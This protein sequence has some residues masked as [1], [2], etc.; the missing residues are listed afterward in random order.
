MHC[1][2]AKIAL[3]LVK[4]LKTASHSASGAIRAAADSQNIVERARFIW[5]GRHYSRYDDGWRG[6]GW[7]W[8][9]YAFRRG[10]G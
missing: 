4:F 6:P 2:S 5:L 3:I 8:C 1:S 7:Y 10:S 9:G